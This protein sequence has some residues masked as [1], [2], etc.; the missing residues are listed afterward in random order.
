MQ[1]NQLEAAPGPDP[2]NVG[3]ATALRRPFARIRQALLLVYVLL[4]LVLAAG[5]L[6][7]LHDSRANAL[8]DATQHSRMLVRIL[9][10]HLARTLGE[11]DKV[12][13]G[14][15]E[16]FTAMGGLEKVGEK[17]VHESLKRRQAR[18]P[19]VAAFGAVL[20]DGR[21]LARTAE[22]PV[23]PVD[24][25]DWEDFVYLR[26]R[27]GEAPYIGTPM[28]HAVG[29]DLLIHLS[30]RLTLPDGRFAGIIRCGITSEYLI[31]FYDELKLP[32]ET[33]LTLVK[34]DGTTVFR[35]PLSEKPGQQKLSNTAA[36]R[37]GRP[38][39]HEGVFEDFLAQ[40]DRRHLVAYH[41]LPDASLGVF[42]ALPLERVYGASE[43]DALRAAVGGLLIAA[44]FG[45]LFRLVFRTLRREETLSAQRRAAELALRDSEAKYRALVENIPQRVF[46]KDRQSRYLAVNRRYAED[47]G[48]TPGEIV[49]KDDF[50]LSPP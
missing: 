45:A 20:P 36:F 34:P 29:T 7:F 8:E 17:T 30:R 9:E 28:K 49:G 13:Q 16:Q 6:R 22:Y 42:I 27:A 2:E 14:A 21:L 5:V 31:R 44:V 19:Q 4:L 25:S 26:D 43:R 23:R 32:P 40:E 11:A 37:E 47:K 33:V 41:W 18:L 3:G 1:I 24:M 48:L 39:G 15:V 35:L 12:L 50:A 10:E 46:Y 38:A